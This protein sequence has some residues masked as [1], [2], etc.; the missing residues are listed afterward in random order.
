[1]GA[2]RR[3]YHEVA[4][5]YIFTQIKQRYHSE[6]MLV[7]TSWMLSNSVLQRCM[8]AAPHFVVA[9]YNYLRN[10]KNKPFNSDLYLSRTVLNQIMPNGY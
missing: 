5:H 1:M 6:F 10:N 2:V 4:S 8:V 3:N 7:E 9:E